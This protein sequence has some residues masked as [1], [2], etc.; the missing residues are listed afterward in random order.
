MREQNESDESV[1]EPDAYISAG[2]AVDRNATHRATRFLNGV[3]Q[4]IFAENRKIQRAE[5]AA[6]S[7]ESIAQQISLLQVANPE[8]IFVIA[9]ALTRIA[10]HFDPPPP[11]V[12]DS[13]YIAKKLGCTTTWV[14]DMARNGTIP[15][16]CL[17]PG[18]GNGKLWKFYRS[19][20]EKWL[21]ER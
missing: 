15:A 21:E 8:A 19:K 12:V 7:D 6:S 14:A 18:T 16:S 11:D 9:G 5:Q 4:R 13:V 10:N 20:I 1:P 17:V 2:T 3:V